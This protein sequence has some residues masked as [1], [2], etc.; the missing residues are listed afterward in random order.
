MRKPCDDEIQDEWH[1]YFQDVLHIVQHIH[2]SFHPLPCYLPPHAWNMLV[3]PIS[4]FLGLIYK[5]T[6]KKRQFAQNSYWWVHPLVLNKINLFEQTQRDN[7][8]TYK[9]SLIVHNVLDETMSHTY[10]LLKAIH[11]YIVIFICVLYILY[12]ISTKEQTNTFEHVCTPFLNGKNFDIGPF[13]I[14][15]I[16]RS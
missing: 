5:Y 14:L 2:Y 11:M 12:R 9:C 13:Y 7:L 16:S 3:H 8:E 10:G 1:S 4:D 15:G 6:F